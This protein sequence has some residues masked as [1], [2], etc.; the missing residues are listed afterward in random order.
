MR[1]KKTRFLTYFVGALLLAC[2]APAGVRAQEKDKEAQ[3]PA[4]G[5]IDAWR[6]AL[7]PEAETP[8]P[9]EGE[10][11]AAPPRVSREE[12]EAGLIALERKWMEALRQRDA[13]ALSQI[14]ADDFALV[15]PQ[16][17]VAAGDKEKYFKHAMRELNLASYDFEELSVRVYGRTAV[18]S[19]RLKQSANAAG[20]DWG[21]SYLVTDVWVSRGGFWWVVSRHASLLP[22]KK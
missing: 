9:A 12:V 19:A 17:V 13:S 3:K 5:T 7:P 22:L 21:G 2:A 15:S 11:D 10:A 14:I 8:E 20:E 16:L 1:D 18:V 6:G 4:S